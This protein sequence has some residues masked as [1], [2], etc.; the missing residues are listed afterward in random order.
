MANFVDSIITPEDFMVLQ[1]WKVPFTGFIKGVGY[2]YP[3]Y[4]SF[5]L[6]TNW[7]LTNPTWGDWISQ[8][9]AVQVIDSSP[10]AVFRSMNYT[11]KD[12]LEHIKKDNGN[13]TLTFTIGD[14]SIIV[15]ENNYQ[16]RINIDEAE[17]FVK[18]GVKDN[19]TGNMLL[20]EISYKSS[21]AYE[22][23]QSP[24]KGHGKQFFDRITADV[25][26][27]A[28]IETIGDAAGG[29]HNIML[30]RGKYMPYNTRTITGKWKR[31]QKTGD[32]V[33]RS[34]FWNFTMNAKYLNIF[35]VGGKILGTAGTVITIGKAAHDVTKDASVKNITS[36]AT[37]SVIVGLAFIPVYGWAIALVAGLA[38]GIYG[39]DFYDFVD[40]TVQNF[41]Y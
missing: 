5:E 18:I 37:K 30:D 34:K 21:Q 41:K 11:E 22:Q 27:D 10:E 17:G 29:V 3:E 20:K 16:I 4:R 12:I 9:I 8:P 38:D 1:N 24:E 40:D 32:I 35:R 19:V 13:G 6:P 28:A 26:R 33:I 2:T 23:L 15:P 14:Q 31:M 25:I 39:D 36:L 7:S